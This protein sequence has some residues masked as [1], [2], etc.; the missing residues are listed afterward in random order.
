MLADSELRKSASTM[1]GN[2]IMPASLATEF[3][4]KRSLRKKALKSREL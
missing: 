1:M 2:R 3:G 4:I